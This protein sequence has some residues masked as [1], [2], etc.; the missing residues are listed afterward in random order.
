MIGASEGFVILRLYLRWKSRSCTLSGLT[1]NI[2]KVYK[3]TWEIQHNRFFVP[4]K[5]IETIPDALGRRVTKIY[6]SISSLS[7]IRLILIRIWS[8]LWEQSLHWGSNPSPSLLDSSHR[9]RISLFLFRSWRSRDR[10]I[11]LGYSH[12]C[13]VCLCGCCWWGRY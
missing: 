6:L 12:R 13:S 9:W 4:L 3:I 5:Q 7:A 8:L 2:K 1:S 10:L 11:M